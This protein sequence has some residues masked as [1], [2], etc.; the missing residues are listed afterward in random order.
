LSAQQW[1]LA[2]SRDPNFA[3][4][5]DVKS[6][7]SPAHAPFPPALNLLNDLYYVMLMAK[8]VVTGAM[9]KMKHA[10]LSGNY[11]FP[12]GLGF[13]GQQASQSSKNLASLLRGEALGLY[14]EDGQEWTGLQKFVLVDVHT[15][16]GPSGVDTLSHGGIAKADLSSLETDFFEQAFPLERAV[17][18]VA[19]EGSEGGVV[20]G[21]KSSSEQ[22][23]EVFAGYDLMM[24]DVDRFCREQLLLSLAAVAPRSK[25]CMTQ[26]FGTY[27]NTV[28]GV[29]SVL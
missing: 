4:Y 20:G 24:G 6:V 5:V 13:G 9:G 27:S 2:L 26:E 1:E 19:V 14:T 25:V 29:V 23:G 15:G 11:H 16:L 21:A 7:L 28:V 12:T 8:V 17:V 18:A 3:E 10:L 22:G